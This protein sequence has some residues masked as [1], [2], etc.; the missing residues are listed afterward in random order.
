MNILLTCSGRRNYII[1]YFKSALDGQNQ[2][3][4]ANNT[5]DVSSMMV[6]DEPALMPSIYDNDYIDQLLDFCDRREV[7]LVVPLFDLELPILARNKECF[8]ERGVSVAVSSLEVCTTC[9]DKVRSQELLKQEGFN[10]TPVFT[11]VNA[12]VEA[13]NREEIHFPLFVKPRVGMGSIGVYEVKTRQ[14]LRACFEIVKNDI[15]KSY[16]SNKSKSIH[17]SNVIV[18]ERLPGSHYL[19][20]IVNDFDE[21]YVTTIVKKP[22][23]NWGGEADGAVTQDID[24]LKSLGKNISQTLGHLG[25]LDTDVFWDGES[26]YILEMNPRFGGGY[27]F[28]HVAGANL[29]AAYLA[30]AEGEEPNPSW[31]EVDY[32]VK[33]VKGIS[34]H[35]IQS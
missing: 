25:N 1:D 33:S 11:D 22:I 23:S 7:S 3:Y 14:Q 31:F 24:E 34:L 29:P 32:G 35:K 9:L 17:R 5:H 6:C 13:L 21:N 12:A 26:A 18:Q 30:W 19:L 10:T 2:V 28:S 4:A 16:L 27:P 20:D 15:K 8:S